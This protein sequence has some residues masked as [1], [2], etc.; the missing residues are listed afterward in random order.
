M[1]PLCGVDRLDAIIEAM[2]IVNEYGMDGISIGV[3]VAFAMDCFENGIIDSK[4]TGG[5]DLRF[6]NA[7][8]MV[9]MV[10]K[11]A[12]RQDIGDVLAEGVEERLG[13]PVPVGASRYSKD[14]DGH[15]MI[16]FP[17]GSGDQQSPHGR[18]SPHPFVP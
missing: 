7:E 12:L 16:T 5:L 8:A 18:A 13:I 4:D 15:R 17:A 6:G 14:S 1:G 9:E 10:K 2:R 11:I 3:V